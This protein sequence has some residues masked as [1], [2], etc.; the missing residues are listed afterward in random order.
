MLALHQHSNGHR[1]GKRRHEKKPQH[2]QLRA[3]QMRP[4]PNLMFE[5]KGEQKKNKA[6]QSRNT[7]NERRPLPFGIHAWFLRPGPKAVEGIL[8]ILPTHIPETH[9]AP[10]QSDTANRR[11]E[12]AFLFTLSLEGPVRL[13]PAVVG[14]RP[15]RGG[16][17]AV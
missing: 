17:H 6:R 14:A 9:P 8:T 13:S 15:G 4:E 12:Q 5:R 7:P 1:C 2:E 16:R 11:V 10:Y 3:A